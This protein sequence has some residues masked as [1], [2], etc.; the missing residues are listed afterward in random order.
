MRNLLK[1]SLEKLLVVP[2]IKLARKRPSLPLIAGVRLLNGIQMT[3]RQLQL[4]MKAIQKK[5]PCKFLVF[6]LGNDSVFWSLL[7]QGGETVFLE[8]NPVWFHKITKRTPEIT[9]YL[10]VYDT[11]RKDWKRLLESPSLLEVSLPEAIKEQDWDIVLVDAPAGYDDNTPGRMKSIYTAS[12]LVK[13][14]GDVFVHDCNR[15]IEDIF[16]NNFLKE[17]NLTSEIK[18][19]IGNL[20]YYNIMNR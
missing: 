3:A 20:R 13:N 18:S 19:P 1:T 14:A 17:E 7:N 15:E 9:A 2:G 12:K 5:A 8:D 6:G 11:L 16:C 10:V 4:I